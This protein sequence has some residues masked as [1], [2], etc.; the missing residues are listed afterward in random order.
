EIDDIKKWITNQSFKKAIY[1]TVGAALPEAVQAIIEEKGPLLEL[2]H[3]TP[4]PIINQYETPETLG[5]DR[6]AAVLGAFALF[7]DKVA[8]VIDAGTC[9]TYDLLND[10]RQYKGGNISPG[11]QMRLDA[12]HHFTAKLPK[13]EGKILDDWLG[14]DTNSALQNGAYYGL[15]AELQAYIDKIKKKYPFVNV[16]LTG[17]DADFFAK[18]LKSKIFVN[19]NL[20]LIG[21][22]K[23]LHYNV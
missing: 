23:T 20:V 8:L 7:P 11:W 10:H 3:R 5:K 12:M 18:N 22:N 2:D 16:I 13:P 15:L 6:L 9:V 17:G 4:L 1:C 19:Q 21:L 14:R